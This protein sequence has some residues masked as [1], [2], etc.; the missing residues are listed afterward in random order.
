MQSRIMFP[1]SIRYLLAVAEH[2][3]FTRAADA[4]C[5]SQPTLSQQIKLLEEALGIQL[6]DR[7]A[8]AVQLT[9]A[10]EVYLHHARRALQELDA[11]KRAVSEVADLSRG[12]LRLGMT[13]V[14]EYLTST[15]LEEFGSR[16][17]GIHI[18]ALEMSQDMIEAAV[19]ENNIDLG[20]AFTHTPSVDAWSGRIE[21]QALFMEP[22]TLALGET[23][24]LAG[25]R[26]PV[27]E[28]VFETEPMVLLNSNFA[29]RRHFDLYCLERGITPRVA[30]ESNSLNM[31]VQAVSLGRMVTVLPT[32]IACNQPRIRA[33][34]LQRKLPHHTIAL[35]CAKG[36]Y[37]SPSCHAFVNLAAHW[38]FSR[39][40]VAS[41]A[42]A[43]PC[44]M[45]ESCDRKKKVFAPATRAAESARNA[46]RP[47]PA[48]AAS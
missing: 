30:L 25:Q 1:R 31:V 36:A 19:A 7:S 35:V 34:P 44:P 21:M 24:V 41:P 16:Y 26:K 12:F 39:C 9:D 43:D 3:S 47:K 2:R 48:S 46:S 14:T 29:L 27:S 20:I 4:L 5:V 33:V 18:S 28:R 17:P 37:R 32:T 38:N 6:L 8:R 22:L 42:A 10:G 11:G 13:P 45:S 23:H 40:P 15:L